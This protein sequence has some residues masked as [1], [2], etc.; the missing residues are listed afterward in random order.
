MKNLV[1]GNTSQLSYYFPEDYEKISSRNI[2]IKKYEPFTY[3]RILEYDRVFITFAEQRTF[4]EDD[5]DLFLKTNVD[6]TL[7][8]IDFFSKISKKIIVYGTCEL[9]NNIEGPINI[10]D[11][12]NYNYTPYIDSKR[13]MIENLKS[14]ENIIILHP[15]N[16]NSIYRKKGFLFG[17]IFDSIINK[18]KIEIGDT[19]FYRDL[20]H[21]KYVV[22]RSLLAEADEIIGSGRLTFINDFIRELYKES[23]LKYEEYVIE[24][25]DHNLSNKRKINYAKSQDV[26]YTNL[27]NDTI[28]DIRLQ[29]K[30]S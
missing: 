10:N 4:I 17:K 23:G 22:E 27:L 2:D 20:V 7:D 26:L 14:R 16:F 25:F 11:E 5:K 15:F 19:Y 8:I 13:I 28:N 24:N 6:Y 30:I 9:W 12:F 3:D 21:P 18:T 29:N 1:I